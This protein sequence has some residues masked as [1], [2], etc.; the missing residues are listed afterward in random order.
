M[1]ADEN[2]IAADGGKAGSMTMSTSTAH[3]G[4]LRDM[5]TTL[6]HSRLVDLLTDVA[7]THPDV[8]DYLRRSLR[9]D[10]SL[11]RLFVR[12]LSRDCSNDDLYNAFAVFGQI[13]EAVVMKE[14]GTQVCKGFGFVTFQDADA[15][16]AALAVPEKR[17]RDRTATVHLAALG[18]PNRR[19]PPP[20]GPPLRHRNRPVDPYSAPDYGY[21]VPSS[22]LNDPEPPPQKRYR[23]DAFYPDRRSYPSATADYAPADLYYGNPYGGFIQNQQQGRHVSPYSPPGAYPRYKQC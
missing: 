10:S 5:L 13:D 1:T 7:V 14:R 11:R 3:A 4:R 12:G 22:R 8:Q 19:G 6:E 17:I 20:S 21:S 2:A 18:N 16:E 23:E 9:S 15:A